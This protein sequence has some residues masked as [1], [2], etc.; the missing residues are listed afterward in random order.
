[1]AS[2][3]LSQ[4][5]QAG[6]VDHSIWTSGGVTSTNDEPGVEYSALADP[7]G[8]DRL[9]ELLAD[10][11]RAWS[12]T[13]IVVWQEAEDAALGVVIGRRLE[14]PV[15]RTW[16]ADGLIAHDRDL[17]AGSR[18]LIVIDS[19]LRLRAIAAMTAYIEHGEAQL[20]GVASLIDVRSRPGDAPVVSLVQVE[21]SADDGNG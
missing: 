16:D 2:D 18:A 8:A 3:V 6:G 9:A 4:L 19:A 11:V 7:A 1:M 15:I 12:P 17:P 14:I 21:V 5:L 10:R 20:V 13:V